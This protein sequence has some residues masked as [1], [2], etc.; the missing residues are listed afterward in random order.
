MTHPLPQKDNCCGCSVCTNACAKKAITMSYDKEGFLYPVVDEQLCVDC[1]ICAKVCPN[2]NTDNLNNP[3]SCVYGGYSSDPEVMQNCT[4]G[5]FVTEL[6]KIVVNSGGVVAG[7]RYSDDYVKAEYDIA[8]SNDELKSFMGSKYVQSEKGDIYKKVKEHLDSAE[9]KTVLF[10]GCPCDVWALKRYLKK[11]YENLITCE[12][13]CMGVTSYTV[14]EQYKKYT[15]KKNRSSLVYINARSK[16]KGWYVPHLEERF[17][18]GKTKLTTLFG[19]MYGYGFQVYNRPS[20][21][22][23][24]Y[25]GENGVADFRVGDFWGIKP[26]DAFWNKDG[27]SCIFVRTPKA[28]AFIKQLSENGFNLYETQYSTATEN[29]M[30]SYKNKDEK[31]LKLRDRF[32]EIYLKDGLKSACRKTESISVKLKRILPADIQPAVKRIYHLLYDKKRK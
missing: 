31:Y 8:T 32:T 6:S 14:A 21:F 22:S 20:C 28:Q 2:N 13:V 30:S 27:V 4:S 29:N 17:V 1:G 12:L 26:E 3:F 18:N 23:C 11:D 9:K 25:R 24:H 10:V 19:T 7:V 5:G 16:K 15:E